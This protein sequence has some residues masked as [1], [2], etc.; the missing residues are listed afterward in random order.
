[1]SA[2]VCGVQGSGKSHTVSVLLENMLIPG[3]AKIGSLDRAL[4]G[5]VLHFGEAGA[6]AQPS[7]AAWLACPLDATTRA[8][9]VVVYVSPSSLETMRK[10]YAK[11]SDN[12]V[13]QPLL[14][15]KSELDA[16]A[17]LSLMAVNGSTESAPL[18]MQT[19]LVSYDLALQE[20]RLIGKICSPSCAS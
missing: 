19:I 11:V 13:V 2:V 9:R 7:E 6:D 5:L 14:F 1:M 12:I 18:Y 3:L 15:R 4:S 10:V 17:F 8:P 20:C 16:Q